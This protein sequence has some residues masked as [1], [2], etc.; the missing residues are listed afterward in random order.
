VSRPKLTVGA[1]AAILLITP[2]L[3]QASASSR[4][5]AAS[6]GPSAARTLASGARLRVYTLG[7]PTSTQAVNACLKPLGPP[8]RL[9]PARP[10]GKFFASSMPG[11]FGLAAPW[12]GGYEVRT[13]GQD[14][15][16]IFASARNLRTQHWHRCFVNGADRPLS[17][18]HELLMTQNG[19]MAW[20]TTVPG[21]SDKA[22]GVCDGAGRRIVAR[23]TNIEVDSLRLRGSILSWTESGV[24]RSAE[25]S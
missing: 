14:G 3:L 18:P 4:R 16:L 2:T 5:A 6:C 20:A 19:N 15:F 10:N 11:P 24:S 23:G 13:T 21:S 1:I 9:G 22:V 7:G 17:S 12:A 8:R 25:L